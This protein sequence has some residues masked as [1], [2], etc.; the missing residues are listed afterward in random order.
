MAEGETNEGSSSKFLRV[1]CPRCKTTHTIY[2]KSSSR[3]KCNGCGYL[4]NKPRG[5][6]TKVRAPIREVY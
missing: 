6:K 3:V 2:G 4:L 5:G 1:L